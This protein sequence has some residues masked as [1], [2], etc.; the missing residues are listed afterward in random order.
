M[1]RDALASA[2]ARWRTLAGERG[3]LDLSNDPLEGGRRFYRYGS[4]NGPR[5]AESGKQRHRRSQINLDGP[6]EPEPTVADARA[7]ADD[8]ELQGGPR[9]V[10]ITL[11]YLEAVHA[12]ARDVA[13]ECDLGPRV[14]TEELMRGVVLPALSRLSKRSSLIS[15]VPPRFKGPAQWVVSHAW[16]GAFDDLVEAVSRDLAPPPAPTKPPLPRGF[17][18]RVT[19]WIDLFCVDLY[20]PPPDC[21]SMAADWV[22]PVLHALPACSK[23]LVLAVD[24]RLCF[25]TW[26]PCL[27][28]VFWAV[29]THGVATVRMALPRGLRVA[30]VAALHDAVAAGVDFSKGD[31][32]SG[33]ERTRVLSDLRR[34]CG[35]QR[36]AAVVDECLRAALHVKLRWRT[37]AWGQAMFA[38]LALRGPNLLLLQLMLLTIP[39]LRDSDKSIEEMR[40]I[41]MCYD[42]D[43]SGELDQEEFIGF[44]RSADYTQA[45]AEAAFREVNTDGEG[46][47]S[48]DE[49]EA[50][51]RD[52]TAPKDGDGESLPRLSH[53][54]LM[55]N[56]ESLAA[57]MA[58]SGEAE[59]AEHLREVHAQRR[60]EAPAAALLTAPPPRANLV[61]AVDTVIQRLDGGELAVA[62][63]HLHRM[64][65]ANTELLS[66]DVADLPLPDAGLQAG[67][68]RALPDLLTTYLD[69]AL[70]LLR[71]QGT[72]HAHQIHFLET[73]AA[74]LRAGG[75]TGCGRGGLFEVAPGRRSLAGDRS[76]VRQLVH[77]THAGSVA[78]T[79][80]VLKDTQV[81]ISQLTASNKTSRPCT[82]A[83]ATQLPG[84]AMAQQP[85]ATLSMSNLAMEQVPLLSDLRAKLHSRGGMSAA[86]PL[87]PTI[88]TSQPRTSIAGVRGAPV[89]LKCSTSHSTATGSSTA[90]S[91][92]TAGGASTATCARTNLQTDPKSP[93][94]SSTRIT[95]DLPF[96]RMNTDGGGSGLWSP[97]RAPSTPR[98]N[99]SAPSPSMAAVA[100]TRLSFS[101]VTGVERS[102]MSMGEL[103]TEKSLS[104]GHTVCNV[105]SFTSDDSDEDPGVGSLWG[106]RRIKPHVPVIERLSLSRCGTPR[107]RERRQS[108]GN[109]T[110]SSLAPSLCCGPTSEGLLHMTQALS[111]IQE[112]S[113]KHAAAARECRS[114]R[115]IDGNASEC[116]TPRRRS[117]GFA[118]SSR[119]N[120]GGA[121]D[122]LGSPRIRTTAVTRI[123]TGRMA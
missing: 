81:A 110:L 41:F 108:V 76:L 80:A 104:Q 23:G 9:C 27:Y 35:M 65:L 60:D 56:L 111:R 66:V 90:L 107:D 89:G 19:L 3:L 29:Q 101:E 63:K 44:L 33:A 78:L 14:T 12:L 22:P 105:P 55:A 40:R 6:D 84:G 82:P 18:D 61:S 102:Y 79:R 48:I 59:L 72:A 15:V 11:S 5:G 13:D 7:G 95:V 119:S 51:W 42:N 58:R 115:E 57:F 112:S 70:D 99:T 69:V 30:D 121:S 86:A 68:P 92:A 113:G 74:E 93:R 2:A 45:E 16:P 100:D 97:R 106:S 36:S 1:R 54:A 94:R 31:A 43:G 91:W 37:A 21:P 116:D 25:L 114:P 83:A 96:L 71:C 47:V 46:G 123:S 103:P 98:S 88:S 39:E 64:L 109:L 49:F 85:R 28:E 117:S 10:G 34:K 52:Q 87:Q 67:G 118:R 32:G 62:A 122:G 24:A 8:G 20:H 53:G 17:K 77:V 38:T 26:L 73:S 120:L 4:A 75:T 50:W